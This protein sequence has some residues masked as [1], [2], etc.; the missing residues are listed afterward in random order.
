[1]MALDVEHANGIYINSLCYISYHILVVQE[2]TS[3][4]SKICLA[5]GGQ[6][7][8]HWNSYKKIANFLPLW[9]HVSASCVCVCAHAHQLS[10]VSGRA[11]LMKYLLSWLSVM[12]PLK[13]FYPDNMVGVDWL[14]H[15]T[16]LH[17]TWYTTVLLQC[18]LPEDFAKVYSCMVSDEPVLQKRALVILVCH[19]LLL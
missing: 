14:Y 2:V 10:N 17:G 12:W 4:N 15:C 7:V 18:E 8:E 11:C 6:I 9:N 5:P 13:W 3:L 19:T 16:Q 1:M